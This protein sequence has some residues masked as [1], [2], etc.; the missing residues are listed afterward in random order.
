MNGTV[1]QIQQDFFT[2]S[3]TVLG[4]AA[5][6]TDQASFVIQADSDF[7]L[8]KMEFFASIAG[9]AQD[10]S[11]RV[12]PLVTAYIQ[13]TSSGRYLSDYPIPITSLFGDGRLPFILPNPRIFSSRSTV[14]ITLANFSAATTYDI[15]L[16]FT[17]QKVYTIK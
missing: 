13:E 4:L 15:R 12:I 7:K 2:Y 1:A 5:Q 3:A 14:T 11:T 8:E 10:D 9:A 6:A 16:A 17:G